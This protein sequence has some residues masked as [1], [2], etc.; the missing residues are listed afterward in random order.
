MR[1]IKATATI[2][3]KKK[4]YSDQNPAEEVGTEGVEDISNDLVFCNVTEGGPNYRDV[5]YNYT[6]EYTLL[7][8]EFA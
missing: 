2:E 3:K 1:T 6:V 7:F 8:R 5:S 4:N